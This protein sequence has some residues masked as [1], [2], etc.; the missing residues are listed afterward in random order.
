M[1]IPFR[2]W[3]LIA[4]LVF[5]VISIAPN[6]NA[7]GVIIHQVD[8]NSQT[9]NLGMRN[10][11]KLLSINDIEIKTVN[12]VTGSLSYLEHQPTEIK[13]NTEVDDVTI[14]VITDIDLLLDFDLTVLDS[15]HPELRSGIKITGVEGTTVSSK[16]EFDAEINK[17]LPTKSL[18]IK[19]DGATIAYLARGQP[20]F[21]V[22][23]EQ[24]S[25]IKKGLDLEGGTRVLIK[26]SGD[27]IEDSS[28]KDLIAVL[29]NRLDLYGLSDL[30]IRQARDLEGTDF[31]LI[32][33]AGLSKRDIQDILE[34]QGKFEAKI[35]EELVFT[36]GKP[37][38]QYVCRD[39]GSCSGVH[40]CTTTNT[41]NQ[42]IFQFS[43][44]I[45]Q[46]A[47]QRHSV[48]TSKL[49]TE[50]TDAGSEILSKQ[51]D[52]Y[53]DNRLVSSLNIDKSLKG[54]TTQDISISG[55]GFGESRQAAEADAEQEMQQLQTVLITGS[56]P[57]DITI[58][59]LD[60][61]SPL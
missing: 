56:L 6:P 13:I 35:G 32:E 45:G 34:A 14:T 19:T 40:S 21:T 11:Q 18:N 46:D 37:D 31:I 27:N 12:D 60:T 53:L 48:I 33:I 8:P 42:C 36:G 39:D 24:T 55:P 4:A 15:G 47:A 54:S 38:I 61:I 1:K 44:R 57:L 58:E 9:Y 16:E 30:T 2:V 25:N 5:S 49:E 52:F 10:N 29:R 3:I 43:I 51:I 59:K 20:D 23:K 28:I 17:L 50:V 26:V 7:D 41:G 22:K